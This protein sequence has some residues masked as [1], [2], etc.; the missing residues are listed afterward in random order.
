MKHQSPKKNSS[1]KFSLFYNY[2]FF[3]YRLI[4]NVEEGSACDFIRRQLHYP[5][6]DKKKFLNK[7][8]IWN[9]IT[10]LQTKFWWLPWDV[11]SWRNT[12]LNAVDSTELIAQ[13]KYNFMTTLRHAISL[14]EWGP[15]AETTVF[16]SILKL[17]LITFLQNNF[18]S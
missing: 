9:L 16:F 4:F 17:K 3:N 1:S 13:S 7:L 8:L 18:F 6:H 15:K 11:N 12:W 5:K 2:F 14:P 10:I